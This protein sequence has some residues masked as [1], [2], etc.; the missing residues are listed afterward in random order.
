MQINYLST[1]QP[2]GIP[3]YGLP[4]NSVM[5]LRN[6]TFD[7]NLKKTNNLCKEFASLYSLV[8]LNLNNRVIEPPIDNISY[9][10]QSCGNLH[11]F[12]DTNNWN[13]SM[14]TECKNVFYGSNLPSNLDLYNWNFCNTKNLFYLIFSGNNIQSLNVINWNLCNLQ[15][16]RSIFSALNNLTYANLSD[17][18]LSSMYIKDWNNTF[19]DMRDVFWETRNLQTFE[20]HNW[21]CPNYDFVGL[22]LFSSSSAG[23]NINKLTNVCLDNIIAANL[24]SLTMPFYQAVNLQNVI[25]SNINLAG[26]ENITI[27]GSY[28]PIGHLRNQQMHLILNNWNICN[29]N[30]FTGFVYPIR[31]RIKELTI[32][33]WNFSGI[34]V[35]LNNMFAY[36]YE[37]VSL[38]LNNWNT[39][40][41]MFMNGTFFNCRNIVDFS[42][43]NN[44]NVSNVI[45]MRNMFEG[46]N[47]LINLEL[48]NWNTC[49]LVNIREF[50]N[51]CSNLTTVNFSNWNVELL[52]DCYKMFNG[53]ENLQN[54]DFSNWTLNSISNVRLMFARTN[55]LTNDTL[56]NIAN[57]ML[58]MNMALLSSR[59]RNVSVL[60]SFSLFN[61]CSSN[62]HLSN[63]ILGTDMVNALKAKGWTGFI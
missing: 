35:L 22:E 43:I 13:L 5:N 33:N 57:L 20:M 19:N 10:F 3:E 7:V 53:C 63:D 9:L 1:F 29:C 36:C 46:C 56:K 26:Y 41:V 52:S 15:Y 59:D 32:E 45:S 17:W 44:F 27:D 11:N 14:V 23:N 38:N 48:Q 54:I 47:N 51:K 2:P 12:G 49:N 37:M 62:M 50:C 28:S 61:N 21:Y 60:N 42:A 39:T 30:N 18:N 25:I 31:N 34:N 24:Y 55:N 4:Y 58:N 40:N 6:L 8:N 16:C